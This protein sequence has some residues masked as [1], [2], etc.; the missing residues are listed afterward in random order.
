MTTAD[1]KSVLPIY[2]RITKDTPRREMIK[3]LYDIHGGQLVP[4]LVFNPDGSIKSQQALYLYVIESLQTATKANTL[5][6]LNALQKRQSSVTSSKP[7]KPW[8]K[9]PRDVRDARRLLLSNNVQSP[10]LYFTE[11]GYPKTHI[12]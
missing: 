3:C 2:L 1:Y 8:K 12:A 11:N 4:S 10:S 9:A 6:Y 7:T 5:S